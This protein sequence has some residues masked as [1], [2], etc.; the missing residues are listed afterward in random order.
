VLNRVFMGIGYNVRDFHII[1]ILVELGSDVRCREFLTGRS[2]AFRQSGAG[3][4]QSVVTPELHRLSFVAGE[5]LC[6]CKFFEYQIGHGTFEQF[7]DDEG[8]RS[9]GDIRSVT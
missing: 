3:C 6:L 1:T 8:R 4:R 9:W 7:H 5:G 2:N